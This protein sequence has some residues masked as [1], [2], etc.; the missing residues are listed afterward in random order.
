MFSSE[1]NMLVSSKLIFGQ[2][3]AGVL[4]NSSAYYLV[5]DTWLAARLLTL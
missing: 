5:A 2:I 4:P 3:L 1:R